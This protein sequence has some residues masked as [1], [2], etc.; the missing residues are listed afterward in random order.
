MNAE[1]VTALDFQTSEKALALASTLRGASPWMKVGLELFTAEGPSVITELKDMNF[2]VF[3]DLKF[4]DIPNT[5]KGAAK[6]AAKLGADLFTLHHAGGERMATAALEGVGET[7]RP[8]LV[9]AISIL[10]STSPREAGFSCA[11]EVTEAVAAKAREAKSWGLSG[12]VCSGHEAAAVK[13]VCGPEFLCLCPGIRLA[14]GSHDDQ[15]RVMTPKQAVA[16]G[17]DF[18]VVGRAITGA[19]DPRAAANAVLA[20]M[21]AV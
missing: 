1:L 12:I 21:R 9:F 7:G 4:H 13:A 6:S 16:A 8:V 14:G 20:D 19:T 17:A 2:K 15:N 3:L 5:V 18:L 11:E 10:T